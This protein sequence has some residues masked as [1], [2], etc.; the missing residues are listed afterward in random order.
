MC[1][2]IELPAGSPMYG[3]CDRE[4]TSLDVGYCGSRG[5]PLRGR[6][7]CGRGLAVRL[8]SAEVVAI[9]TQE[10]GIPLDDQE[11]F[12]I[13]RFSLVCEVEASGQ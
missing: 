12:R 4:L 1:V 9:G 7:L 3:E 8:V 5:L 6:S 2:G 11:V 13:F 10:H